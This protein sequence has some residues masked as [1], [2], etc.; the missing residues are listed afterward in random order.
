LREAAVA[1]DKRLRAGL[2]DEEVAHLA[3]L[4]AT[5]AANVTS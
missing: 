2:S 1:H 4:L 5:L 3:A